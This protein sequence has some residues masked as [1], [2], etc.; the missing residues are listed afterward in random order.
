[1]AFILK[2]GNMNLKN[3]RRR[4]LLPLWWFLEACIFYYFFVSLGVSIIIITLLLI[5]LSCMLLLFR[6]HRIRA[7]VYLLLSVYSIFFL[8]G[9][10]ILYLFSVRVEQ[11]VW[12]YIAI[13]IIVVANIAISFGGF[14]SNWKRCLP[15][16]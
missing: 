9:M 7:F 12:R 13:F 16:G 11:Y 15:L 10:C 3:Y 14:W 5:F 1:M 8:L 2:K 4:V 6:S